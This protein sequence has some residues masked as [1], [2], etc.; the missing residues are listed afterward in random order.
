MNIMAAIGCLALFAP[1]AER[2]SEQREYRAIRTIDRIVVDG[3]ASERT[4]QR[5][6][7]DDRFVEQ[8]PKLGA[9]PDVRTSIRV[10]YDDLALYVLVDAQATPGELRVRTLRRD[11]EGIFADDAVYVKIDANHDHRNGYLFGVNAEGAQIDALGLDDGRELVLQWDGVWE[12]EVERRDDGYT[13]EFRIPLAI[14]GIKRASER[15]LGLHVSRDRPRGNATYDWRLIVPPR[16]RMAASQFGDLTGLRHLEARRAIEYTPYA[17]ARTTLRPGFSVDPRLRPNIA[18]GGDVRVQIGAGSYVEASLLTDFAQVEADEVQV[19]RDRFPLFFPE[20]RPFFLNG[21]DVFEFGLPREAQLLFSRRI[22]LVDGSPI[23]LL[24]GAKV[25]GRAGSLAYGVLH[26]Q[27]LGSP[28]VPSRG[29]AASPPDS[30]SVGRVRVRLAP[31]FNLGLLAMGRHRFGEADADHAA[32]GIDGLLLSR[33][34]HFRWYSVAAG[35][36]NQYPARAA[37]DGASAAD[38]ATSATRE[39]GSSAATQAEYRGLFVRPL[40]SWSWS[41]RGFDPALGF[42][43]RTGTSK[44]TAGLSLVPRPRRL[45]LREVTF[46]PSFTIETDAAYTRRIGQQLQGFAEASWRNG[47]ELLYGVVS[48]VDDVAQPFVLYGHEIEARRYHGLRHLVEIESPERRAVEAELAYEYIELFGGRVHQPSAAVTARAGK[49]FTVAGAYTHRV[50][51]LDNRERRLNFG[52]ANANVDVAIT[53]SLAF[54]VLLRVDL[55]PEE[56]RVGMQTR[57]RWR[58]APGSD[59]FVVYRSDHPLHGA[60]FHELTVKVAVYLRALVG[61]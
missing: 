16:S 54:D 51:Y 31:S 13:A 25:Y 26:V 3:R 7:V 22:G 33:D 12:A 58:F 42:Y 30:V 1:V 52:F 48:F 15:T 37:E 50:G 38:V 11:N 49:H 5:A 9:K 53:R 27:T 19:A 2:A 6:A 56:P 10:A 46:G 47:V 40:L 17:L 44:Q 24:G 28:S 35:T 39:L 8:Q 14:L 20:R 41:D 55:S 4:W 59:L 43:R 34:G 36:F 57:L 45:G 23:A 18:N 61:R 21:L 29:V 32:G 60:A